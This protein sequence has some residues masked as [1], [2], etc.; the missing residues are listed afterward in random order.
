MNKCNLPREPE[1]R[2]W[3]KQ[4]IADLVLTD[5]KLQTYIKIAKEYVFNIN[6]IAAYSFA[7]NPLAGKYA[8]VIFD[9][10]E[11]I[12]LCKLS[13]SCILQRFT[14]FSLISGVTSQKMI[15]K[16]LGYK[17]NNVLSFGHSAYFSMHGY[18]QGTSDWAC[19]HNM[20]DYSAVKSTIVFKTVVW[21]EVEYIFSYYDCVKSIG[22]RIREAL[23]H[24]QHNHAMIHKYMDGI[25]YGNC[26]L[27]RSSILGNPEFQISKINIKASCQDIGERVVKDW[28][29]NCLR[30]FAQEYECPSIVKD[31]EDIYSQSKRKKSIH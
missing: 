26:D 5:K 6:T 4:K 13:T 27:D 8:S 23:H 20:A 9:K 25:G 17:Y 14:M 29:I 10:E 1:Y 2:E 3:D 31:Q 24:N 22:S 15:V 7:K 18:T 30:I 16:L 28:H 12:V 19:L 21:G 11:G